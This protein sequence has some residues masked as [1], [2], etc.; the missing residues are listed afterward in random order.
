MWDDCST[1][2]TL[3]LAAV[4]KLSWVGRVHVAQLAVFQITAALAPSLAAY[5]IVL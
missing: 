4:A 2:A 3:A 1:W 5:V